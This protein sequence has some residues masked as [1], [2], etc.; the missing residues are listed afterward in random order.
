MQVSGISVTN[1]RDDTTQFTA[2]IRSRLLHR[3]FSLAFEFESRYRRFLQGNADP[4][5]IA[6]APICAYHNEDLH[7][8]APITRELLR[9]THEVIDQLKLFDSHVEHVSI[10]ADSYVNP[11]PPR[12]DQRLSALFFTL[13]ID[14][15]Y[16]LKR[17]RDT[18][19]VLILIDF[20]Q[21]THPYRRMM[22]EGTKSVLETLGAHADLLI[23][24]SNIHR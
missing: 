15:I 20:G 21:W 7:V 3:P 5:L 10:T 2:T 22:I 1:I 11:I 18:I 6:L 19:D 24:R 8:Q 17:N 4:F 12:N 16:T 9:R 13:G 23:I 14:S